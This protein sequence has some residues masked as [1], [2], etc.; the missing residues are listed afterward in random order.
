ML[1]GPVFNVELTTTA[2]RARYYALRV[3]YGGFLLF[4]IYIN[5]PFLYGR[6]GSE[7]PRELS[8][9]ELSSLGASLFSTF[10]FTQAIAVLMLTPAMVSGVIADERQRKT[11][12]YLMASRLTSVE[13]VLGKLAARMLH[14]G[15]FLLLGLPI[16]VMLSFL[17]GVDPADV[18]LFFLLSG[19]TAFFLGAVS[20]LISAYA[21][22]P[23]EAIS[24]VYV[25]EFF[26]LF[27]PS[28]AGWIIP[29]F[30]PTGVAIYGLVQPANELIGWSSPFYV[31]V[32]STWMGSRRSGGGAALWMGGLQLAF[33]ALLTLWT[34]FRLRPLFRKAGEGGGRM[35]R[36]LKGKSFRL[37]PRPE[38]GDDA[39]LWKECYVSRAGTMTR[40]VGGAAL[41]I[42][43]GLLVYGTYDFGKPAYLEL[44]EFGYGSGSPNGARG[45]LNGW[46][47][48][49]LTL[50]GG[51][52]LVWC[53]SS[54]AGALT[55]EREEDTWISLI[56]TPLTGFE[57]LRAKIL[58]VF[59]A[60]RWLALFWL[61]F[62]LTGLFLG[63]VHPLG[64]AASLGA[65][66]V[67]LAFGCCLGMF[68][69]A[70][71]KSSAR[72]LVATIGTLVVLNGAYLLA[73][74]PVQMESTIRLI[75]VTPFV[76]AALLMSYEDVESFRANP[77]RPF[78]DSL[79]VALTC[80][81][82]VLAY[83]VAAAL[84]VAVT[85]G[86]FDDVNDRPKTEGV[87]R[88]K[89]ARPKDAPAFE[90]N[91]DGSGV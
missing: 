80:L 12:H 54:A 83:G 20:I 43:L 17:G 2:R 22:R 73:L 31:L 21:R 85:L 70:S 16:V 61:G 64:F 40:F 32:G 79:D 23:R 11:L 38:C 3:V 36:F 4:L 74:I 71:A 77:A 75:G 82:S 25:L 47:R 7:G 14:V 18:F 55:G 66:A 45:D 9:R 88:P 89:R 42:T 28:L 10:A 46:L 63:A 56:A 76:E 33:G 13:I 52:L 6:H 53:A 59:W 65:T 39:M 69:S 5:D 68:Y 27:G 15:V 86:R 35:R 26:W 19:T 48:F 37:F 72:S 84:L 78:A 81:V 67:F 41:L 90:G 62:A 1:P 51:C 58:G 34:V 87:P 50:M 49:V 44:R 24:T 57:I 29:S 8:P 91:P 60:V 30:G